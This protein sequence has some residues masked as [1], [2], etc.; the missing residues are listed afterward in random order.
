[1]DKTDGNFLVKNTWPALHI[2]IME[3]NTEFR[4]R[5]YVRKLTLSIPV[6]GTLIRCRYG[7]LS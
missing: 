6:D 2:Q 4:V 3:N 1:M 7:Q 5:N